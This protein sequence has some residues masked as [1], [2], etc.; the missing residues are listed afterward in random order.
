MV[1]PKKG[2]FIEVEYTGKVKDSG[3]IFDTTTESIAK[4]SHPR[5]TREVSCGNSNNQ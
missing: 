5:A 2:D 3:E 1:K 4:V